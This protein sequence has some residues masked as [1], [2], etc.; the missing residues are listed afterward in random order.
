MKKLLLF[1]LVILF[2][3]GC[4]KSDDPLPAYDNSHPYFPLVV[5]N[6]WNYIH[7]DDNKDTISTTVG[8]ESSILDGNV[9]SFVVSSNDED[10]VHYYTQVRN[11]YY[12]LIK[13]QDADIPVPI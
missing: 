1:L 3:S 13:D 9:Y 6:T 12:V 10:P 5:G 11:L 8:R 4:Y 7:N 2:I